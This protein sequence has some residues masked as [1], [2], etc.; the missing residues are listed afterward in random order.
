MA[1]N[2]AAKQTGARNRVWTRGIT[3]DPNSAVAV[4]D[5]GIDPDHKAF[6]PGYLG[7][8]DF[9][10]KIVYWHDA[11][12]DGNGLPDDSDTSL[13]SGHGTH[14]AGLAAGAGFASIDSQ[15]RIVNTNAYPTQLSGDYA[16]QTAMHVNKTGTIRIQYTFDSNKGDVVWAKLMFGNKELV[17]DLSQ[18]PRALVSDLETVVTKTDLVG[19]PG[20]AGIDPDEADEFQWNVIEYEITSP[21]QFG[22]YHFVT[23]R[24]VTGS[25]LG[26]DMRFIYLAAHPADVASDGTDPSDGLPYYMGQ[27][28][29]TK[30]F[31]VQATSSYDFTDSLDVMY[32][33]LAANHVTVVNLSAASS[34]FQEATFDQFEDDGMVLVAAAGNSS[35]NSNVDKP[36][37]FASTVAVG[38]LTPAETLAWYPNAGPA[39][40]ILAPGGSNMT[41]GGVI[42]PHNGQGNFPSAW[43]YDL[44]EDDGIGMQG[45]SMST[46]SAAGIFALVYDALGGWDG[47]VANNAWKFDGQTFTKGQKAKHVKRLVFM[48]ATELNTKRDTY[49]VTWDPAAI[50]PV[51]NRGY[52]PS[53]DPESQNWGKDDHEGYGRAN[54]DAAVAAIFDAVQ[55]GDTLDVSLVS[56]R[57]TWSSTVRGSNKAYAGSYDLS[58]AQQAKAFAR[59]LVVSSSELG[60][61]YANGVNVNLQV[62]AG[63]DFD[64]FVYRPDYGPNGQPLLLARSINAGEG[65]NEGLLFQPDVAGTWYVVVK[66]VS[67]EGTASLSVG[68]QPCNCPSNAAPV[69]DFT[70]TTSGLTVDFT[71]QSSDS[72]GT[73]VAHAWTFG[74]GQTSNATSPSVTYASAGTYT[75]TLTVTDDDGAEAQTNATVTVSST[76]TSPPV[77]SFSYTA[78]DLTVSFSDGSSD[79]DGTV[80]SWAWDFGDGQTSSLSNPSVTYATDGTYT[81]TLTVTDDDGLQDTTSQ[82]VSVSAG[83][84]GGSGGGPLQN[85]VGVAVSGL[86]DSY[87]YFQ[88]EVPAG[89]DWLEVVTSGGSGDLDLYLAYDRQPTKSDYDEKSAGPSNSEDVAVSAPAAGTWHILVFAYSDFDGATLTATY[90][91]TPVDAELSNGVPLP[92]LGGTQG[93]ELRYTIDVP[94]GASDLLFTL[95]GGS[96]DLDIYVKYG[97]SATRSDYDG[98]SAG[99]GNSEDV[100][101]ASPSAGTWH[102]LVYAYRESSGATLTASYTGNGGGSGGGGGG[103]GGSGSTY[104]N[105]TTYAIPDG[106]SS[107]VDSPIVVDLSGDAGT[108]TVTT[109]IDHSYIGDLYV[110]LR[111]PDGTT[112]VLHDRSGGSADDLNLNLEVDASGVSAA[113]TWILHVEDQVSLFSGT[114]DAWSISFP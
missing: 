73:V 4:F 15:G 35:Y 60:T 101:F 41:G 13:G 76:S 90:G 67:G 53:L 8:G 104:T 17:N 7:N 77:A 5:T 114:L 99:Y 62:P 34:S 75:V 37:R 16:E 46:P 36:A 23:R 108:V 93:T 91:A 96:G 28:P 88:L 54:V 32:N 14:A 58:K 105:T 55:P 112:W 43:G 44:N 84:G 27:A 97:S 50:D 100:S 30:L 49:S 71:D 83:G 87:T 70:Y 2:H 107:G 59:K 18:S 80:V 69:A 95:E 78:T 52:D 1:G 29:D 79:S 89:Q 85:G 92:G 94:E 38:G 103:G 6:S 86:D 106:S 33:Q 98:R 24:N 56:S 9:A 81:V 110:E 12:G 42:G 21:S 102:I 82:Q 22:T 3:G 63:A 25:G 68:G 31:V 19:T 57:A 47:F 72:D 39:M 48:T 11:D 74:D 113:G 64:L 65:A 61:T 51:L 109:T 26:A 66:A 10:G 40:D 20:L 111:A 45:T